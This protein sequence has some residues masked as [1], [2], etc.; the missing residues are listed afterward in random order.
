MNKEYFKTQSVKAA[1]FIKLF[2]GAEVSLELFKDEKLRAEGY[3]RYIIKRT[4]E[5]DYAYDV[6]REHTAARL[7]LPVD[8]DELERVIKD[9]KKETREFQQEAKWKYSI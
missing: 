4:A 2:T 5:V 7:D 6:Y 3:N 8:A 1:S 9:L